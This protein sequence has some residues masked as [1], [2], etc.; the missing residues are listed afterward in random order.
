M[1]DVF[2]NARGKQLSWPSVV[3]VQG[4]PDGSPDE[5]WTTP[6][7]HAKA[8]AARRRRNERRKYYRMVLLGKGDTVTHWATGNPTP[9]MWSAGIDMASASMKACWGPTVSNVYD[10]TADGAHWAVGFTEQMN[11]LRG[12][13]WERLA[14][15]TTQGVFAEFRR[16][17]RAERIDINY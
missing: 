1:A 10:L 14:V 2:T 9:V 17:A 15:D 16:A 13:H 8:T 6:G 5:P 4:E 7:N 11:N 12:G 3:F